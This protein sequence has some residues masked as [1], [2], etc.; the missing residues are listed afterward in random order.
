MNGM[1][2]LWFLLTSGLLAK[3]LYTIA[4]MSASLRYLRREKRVEPLEGGTA[5]VF[6][7]VPLLR[8]LP[9]LAQLFARFVGFLE[10]FDRLRLVFVTTEREALEAEA[11]A[12]VTRD[13]LLE[14]IRAH[15]SYGERII[16][17]HYPS[18]NRSLAEQLNHAL[19]VINRAAS[20]NDDYVLLYNADSVIGDDSIACLF[21]LADRGI[22]VAQQSALF[23]WNVPELCRQKR[24]FLAAHGIRQSGWTLKR[25]LPRYLSNTDHIPWLPKWVRHLWLVHCVGHGQFV[26]LNLLNKVGGWPE[27]VIGGEDLALGFMLKVFGYHPHPVPVLENAETPSSLSALF[28]QKAV[29]F[30]GTL[31]YF[32]YWNLFSGDARRL[33]AR[34]I[35]IVTVQG[36]ADC[37]RWIIAG[38][39]V[40]FYL[41]LGWYVGYAAQGIAVYLLYSLIVPSF[42]LSAWRLQSLQR[43]PRARPQDLI[44]LY[45]AYSF[46]PIAHSLH[47]M[48]GLGLALRAV[49]DPTFR[50]PKTERAA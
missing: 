49:L 18:L 5:K 1:S 46:V 44:G 24:F 29:W 14:L 48:H 23:L 11:G 12:E 39:L 38:P 21:G 16:L 26:H 6:L 9:I 17:V 33:H 45:L 32:R 30:L 36:I 25:E 7:V 4:A 41:V 19:P 43:F 10:R 20:S 27:V 31:G 8:E 35:L 47:A 37:L 13:R 40:V 2:W 50:R 28:K 3:G 15:P 34:R 42:V 22:P